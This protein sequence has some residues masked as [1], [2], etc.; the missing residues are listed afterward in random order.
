MRVEIVAGDWTITASIL[1]ADSAYRKY[2]DVNK[3]NIN[4]MYFLY[5]YKSYNLKNEKGRL[6]QW[7]L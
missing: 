3:H 2:V 7:L 1:Y 6:E 4:A 5:G